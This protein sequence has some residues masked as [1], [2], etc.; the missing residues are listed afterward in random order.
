MAPLRDRPP[1]PGPPAGGRTFRCTRCEF[2]ITLL[3]GDETPEC[4]R[5]GSNRFARASMFS[6]ETMSLPAPALEGRPLWLDDVRSS[7][8]AQG[9]HVAWDSGDEIEVVSIAEG[10][11]H[12][13]RSFQ[14]QVQLGDP[15]VS[16]RHAV[17]HRSA[18]TTFLLDDH[19]LNGV[20][21]GGEQVDWRPLDDGDEIE[22]GSFCLQYIDAG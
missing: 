1:R 16:R 7:L 20:F 4:P 9:P 19:S 11:T 13:G 8:V 17:I 15:T 12:I 22:I 10:M 18:E 3:E 14:A 2:P 6:D 5:C 21:V